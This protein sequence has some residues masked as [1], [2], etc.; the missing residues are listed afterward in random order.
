VGDVSDAGFEALSLAVQAAGRVFGATASYLICVN[1]ISVDEAKARVGVIA[2]NVAWRRSRPADLPG[3]LRNRMSKGMAD[4]VGWK[5]CPPRCFPDAFEIS[6]DNDCI[7]WEQPPAMRAFLRSG[8]NGRQHCLMAADVRPALGCFSA[9]CDRAMNSGIRGL[10]PGFDLEQALERFL[11]M[12]EQR[13]GPVVLRTE[14][15]EQGLQAAVLSRSS[16]LLLVATT[17]VSICSPFYP[18]VPYWGRCG[19]HFVGLNAKHLPW[20]Y[21]GRPADECM[22]EHWR[23]HSEGL[24]RKLQPPLLKADLPNHPL[25]S[26]SLCGTSIS[27]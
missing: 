12:V 22:R 19:A 3:C 14:L 10:P 27:A 8:R 5:F 4:G 9:Y 17:H 26:K 25:S 23:V 18:H 6:L 1:T 11:E 21:Y 15:D 16:E 20:D 13:D 24:R 2:P 7:I